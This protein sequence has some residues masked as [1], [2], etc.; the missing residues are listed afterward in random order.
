MDKDERSITKEK[1]K[2]ISFLKTMTL[3]IMLILFIGCHKTIYL[4]PEDAIH[5]KEAYDNCSKLH[6]EC[7]EDLNNCSQICDELSL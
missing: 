2:E 1:R 5:Y 7:E 6:M 3:F 4:G